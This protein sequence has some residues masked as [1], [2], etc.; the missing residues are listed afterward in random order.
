[1]YFYLTGA[2]KRRL[3]LE[4]QDSFCR[5]PVYSKIVPFIQDRY[6]FDERP[7]FAIIITGAS[8]N[9]VRLSADNFIGTVMSHSMLAYVGQPVYP[10]EWV[11][12]NVALLMHQN[13]VMPTPPGVYYLEI[14]TAP[15]LA[16]EK[17]SYVIDPLLTVWNEPVLTFKSGVEG[18]GQ[19]QNSPVYK[20]LRLYEN[21]NYLMVEGTDYTVDYPTGRINFLTRFTPG[22]S[23]AADYRFAAPSRGPIPFMWNQADTTTLPGVVLAFGKRARPGDKVAVVVYPDL[24]DVANAYGGKFEV[25]F[26]LNVISRDTTQ[27]EEIADLTVMEILAEKQP[28]LAREGIDLM[29][30]SI[31]GN[32]EE[33]YDETADLY[34]YNASISIQLRADWEV[35]VPMSLTISRATTGIAKEVDYDRQ[36]PDS[37]GIKLETNSLYFATYPVLAGRNNSYQRILERLG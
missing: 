26:D 4:L 22:S 19:L 11:R 28:V 33:T 34:F 36:T 9:H 15:T 21:K 18:E 32:A 2:L 25:S 16:Q 1:M 17:G 35:H 12:D 31:G 37:S 30:I 7:Q 20:T 14:L 29:D 23:V 10:L 24:T 13:G 5:H 6:S 8:A 3:I 27:A